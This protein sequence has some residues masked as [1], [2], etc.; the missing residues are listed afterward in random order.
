LR[1]RVADI[2][3]A[4]VVGVASGLIFFAWDLTGPVGNALGAALPGLQSVLAGGWLFAGVLGALI[5]RK[6]GAALFAELIAAS[7]EALLG[8]QW[9]ALTLLS[10]LVQGLGAEL[11]FAA[12]LYLNYRLFV[13][14][15]A[16]AAA[17]VFLGI[18]DLVVWYAG[19]KPEFAVIYLVGAVVSGAILA[20]FLP[21]LAVRALAR[22]G[23]LS[24]FAAGREVAVRS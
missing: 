9:G 20:G 7:V 11:V 15:L 2:I 13:A 12:F 8:T 17:G 22:T 6:P 1:W 24:R 23:A 4:S 21:W 18:N 3:V 5:V 16:G 10:G 19:S 14:I